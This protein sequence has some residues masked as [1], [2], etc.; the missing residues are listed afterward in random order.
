M[1]IVKSAQSRVD[2]IL[3]LARARLSSAFEKKK[4]KTK[5]AFSSK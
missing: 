2:E 4:Q 5:N 1:I 3:Y